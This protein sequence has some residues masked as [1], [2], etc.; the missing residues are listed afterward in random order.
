MTIDSELGGFVMIVKPSRGKGKVVIRRSSSSHKAGSYDNTKRERE[1]I[2]KLMEVIKKYGKPELAVYTYII[3]A[4]TGEYYTGITKDMILRLKQHNG[5]LS[6]A[7]AKL[8]G[9]VL[10]HLEVSTD[11]KIAR[12]LE[13]KIKSAGAKRYIYRYKAKRTLQIDK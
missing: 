7:T 5:R 13:V 12:K 2:F 6:K 1:M 4:V 3:Q 8:K 10:I 11:R 9:W